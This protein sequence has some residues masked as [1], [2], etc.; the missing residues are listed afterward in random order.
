MAQV[1]ANLPD[2]DI[3]RLIR[4]LDMK[5]AVIHDKHKQVAADSMSTLMLAIE[6]E[7]L[8]IIQ[9]LLD[10]NVDL[11]ALDINGNSA[12]I[13]A[14]QNLSIRTIH[15][16]LNKRYTNVHVKNKN[17]NTALLE[18]ARMGLREIVLL[19]LDKFKLDVNMQ[20]KF[21]DTCLIMAC[22]GSHTST[23]QLLIEHGA[24]VN[25]Q[26]SE[27][28]TALHNACQ[29]NSFEIMKYLILAGSTYDVK[30]KKRKTAQERCSTQE[31]EERLIDLARRRCVLELSVL[32]RSSEN[33][34]R[35]L[36]NEQ[37]DAWRTA[38]SH[39]EIIPSCH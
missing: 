9:V 31:L 1:L 12:L 30:D 22:H 34:F 10:R 3:R 24:F 14:I 8:D 2:G 29:R 38:A 5:P 26:N 39:M 16:L 37:R 28:T 23:A 33:L 20:N 4:L 21:G 36:R 18:A 25:I 15:L 7:H 19:L 17:G 27:G 11:N 6:R 13:I 32:K 35:R